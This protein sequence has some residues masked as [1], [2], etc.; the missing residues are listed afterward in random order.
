VFAA[1]NLIAIGA[2]KAVQD[3]GL[4]VPEDIAMVAFDDL[5]ANLLV[6]PFLTV[7]VQPAYEMGRRATQLLLSRLNSSAS[8]DCQEVVLPFE[9]IVRQ[10][11]GSALS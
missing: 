11:S 8:Q 7:A 5:P 6:F 3:A 4:R 2:F 9:L 10:S 1:N